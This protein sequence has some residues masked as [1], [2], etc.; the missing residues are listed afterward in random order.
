MHLANLDVALSKL[1]CKDEHRFHIRD[2]CH[3]ARRNVLTSIAAKVMTEFIVP[4]CTASDESCTLRR[5][6]A[7]ESAMRS[8]D[9]RKP[10]CARSSSSRQAV[11]SETWNRAGSP[12]AMGH[13]EMRKGFEEASRSRG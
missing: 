3:V 1:E 10:F 7:T 11:C 12:N 13:Q 2:R 4:S 8:S 9:V 6:R 5:S